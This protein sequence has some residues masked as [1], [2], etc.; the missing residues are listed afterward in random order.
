MRLG[1]FAKIFIRP[2]LAETLDAVAAC[3]LD[4][5]QFNFSCAGLLSMPD[6]IAPEAL[7]AI[8]CELRLRAFSVPAVSGTFNMI[9]PNLDRRRQ[10]LRRLEVI[11]ASCAALGAPMVTLCTGTRDPADP[12]RAHPLNDSPEAWHDLLVS[13]EQALKIAEQYNICLGVEPETAN[14]INSAKKARQLLDQLRSPRLKI[15]MDPANLFRTGDGPRMAEILE[16]AFGLLGPDI[17]LAHAKDFRDGPPLNTVAAGRGMLDWPRC[18]ELLRAAGYNGPLILHSLAEDEVPAAIAFLRRL[19]PQSGADP[20]APVPAAFDHD[21]IRFHYQSE[22]AGVPF[23]FQHGLG[24]DLTQPFSLFRPP[25]G[26]RLLGFDCR[27]HGQ[28]HPLGP[29]EKIS[30]QSFADDLLALMDFLQIE[31]AVVGG[32][33][34]GAAVA[35]NFVLR[36][37][38]RALGLVLDRPAWLDTPRRDNMAFFSVI[39]DLLRRHGPQNGLE[40]FKQTNIYQLALA[41]SPTTA[42]SLAGQF[43]QPQAQERVAR[44]EKIPLDCPGPDRRQWRAIAVPTLVLANGRDAIHPLE[45]GVTLAREIPGAEFK[46]LTPKSVSVKRHLEET[47]RFLEDFLLRHF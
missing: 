40:L 16:E 17:A 37:P 22:G 28:T 43:L 24:A 42:A 10:G 11:A 26:I 19:S 14:V 27:A 7:A 18:L 2:T 5:V 45:Y 41:S 29:P 31:K 30:L 32:I 33:S 3:G 4:C 21:G 15:V 36:H 8:A 44:L 39:A 1:I 25:G 34:M 46:E 9:D 38:H 12:W 13:M 35:L 20:S 23:F 6:D 47:Q